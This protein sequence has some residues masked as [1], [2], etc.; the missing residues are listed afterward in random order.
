MDAVTDFTFADLTGALALNSEPG[1]IFNILLYI[2]FFLNLAA[3][4][5]QDDKQMIATLAVGMTLALIVVAKLAI[6]EPTNLGMLVVNAL[7]FVTP[8]IVTGMSKA[9]KSKPLTIF[10]G[11]LG[12]VYFFVYWFI[13]QRNG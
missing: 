8:L 7:I 11:V 9:K 3:F 10:A 13:L 4:F 2:M 1:L 5:M 12:G 6:I